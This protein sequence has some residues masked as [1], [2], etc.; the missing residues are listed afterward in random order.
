V[1]DR[2]DARTAERDRLN[3]QNRLQQASKM[4]AIGQLAGGIAHDFNNILASII[5]YAELIQSGHLR[6]T[7][8]QVDDYLDQVIGAGHRARDLISQMLTFTR[9][10]RGDPKP[11]DVAADQ[12]RLAHAAGRHPQLAST[13]TR[14]SRTAWIRSSPTRC[15]CSRSSSICW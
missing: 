13:S 10:N 12:R 2:T 4:E 8:E 1:H 11:V 6:F 7:P 5:G 9:A 3:L 14:A 15:S